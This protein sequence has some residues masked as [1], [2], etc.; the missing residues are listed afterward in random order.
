MKTLK[1]LLLSVAVIFG[2][3]SCQ[4]LG[5]DQVDPALGES[6]KILLLEPISYNDTFKHIQSFGT[7]LQEA[8]IQKLSNSTLYGPEIPAINKL[9][10]SGSL[11][12]DNTLNLSETLR[13]AS[14]VNAGQVLAVTVYK[15]SEYPPFTLSCKIQSLKILGERYT[16]RT[17]FVRIDLGRESHK[18]KFLEFVGTRER[19]NV[20][21]EVLA[22]ADHAK[23]ESA[24]LSKKDFYRF[25]ASFIVD[26]I[27][28]M[29]DLHQ[30][31]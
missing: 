18:K 13:L 27:I 14:L 17:Q 12:K 15:A 30:E 24:L 19:L 11:V 23:A 16:N 10:K 9:A 21:D 8:S 1:Y 3:N 26:E 5:V 28:K 6:N 20:E 25:S 31:N 29:Q 2:L 22:T 7:S 4:G